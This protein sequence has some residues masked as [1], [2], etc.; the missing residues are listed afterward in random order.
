MSFM[1]LEEP[2]SDPAIIFNA[3]KSAF[4]V[5]SIRI[6]VEE[7]V[8]FCDDLNYPSE[9][10]TLFGGY[11]K[12]KLLE[13]Y[14]STMLLGFSESDKFIDIAASHSHYSTFVHRMGIE[15]YK[16]DLIYPTGISISE[17]SAVPLVGGNAAQ[18]P[19][20][21][22]YFT[23]M[24]LHCSIEHFEGGDDVDFMQEAARALQPQGKIC[25]LPL[26]FG[27]TYHLVTDPQ[28]YV[29]E[30]GS[31]RFEEGIPVFV[32]A[33]YG[34]RHCR[35]YSVEGFKRRIADPE[36]WNTEIFHITNLD[37]L[38]SGLYCQYAALIT[39]R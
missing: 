38:G 8:Q 7:F 13:H 26:Y 11:L 3:L 15:S 37:E 32:K 5:K 35:V 18:L 17:G 22:N 21:D 1:N 19:F 20:R 31:I 39:K 28:V 24:T 4:T 34:N 25:I 29:E 36:S 30:K 33:G 27:E 14:I 16:Q 12:E 6:N 2:K 9:Y 23:K 10:Q